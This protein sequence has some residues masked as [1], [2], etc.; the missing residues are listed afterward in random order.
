[1]GRGMDYQGGKYICKSALEWYCVSECVLSAASR[2][3][4][5]NVLYPKRVQD[6]LSF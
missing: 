6:I 1:M 4:G 3:L 2:S 5:R